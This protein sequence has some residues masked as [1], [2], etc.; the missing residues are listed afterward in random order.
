MKRINGQIKDQ[1]ELAKQ[2]LSWITCAKRTLTTTELQHALGVELGESELDKENF[3]QVEDMVSICA[4]LV[5]VDEESNIIRLVHYTTQEY[6]ERTQS[7]WFPDAQTN[8]TTICV[9]YLSFDE[10]ESG[11]CRTDKEF[12]QRLQLSTLY[13]YAAHNWGHH[14]REA[15]TSC[16]GVIEFL[17]KQAQVDASSQAL[18]AVKR[19]PGDRKY[20]Q[21]VPKRMTGLHLAAYFGVEEAVQFLVGSDSPDPKDSYVRTP[22]SWAAANGHEAIVKLLLD[23]GAKLEIEDQYGR[24]PL[25]RAAANGHEAIVKLLLDKGAKLEIKDQYGRTPLSR[26]AVKGHEASVKLLL[27]NGAELETK[28]QYGQTPL[29][30]AAANGHEAIVKLLEKDAE[31]P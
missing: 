20:S 14:A 23:K 15:S 1:E 4:G 16:Q 30:R 10:F 18:M 27:D 29:S 28:D 6:F 22:L 12:E 5:T 19:W 17:Q 7:Q 8:I 26:A 11:I 21:E 13:D 31:K 9:S 3:S 24:T 25:S 2:V